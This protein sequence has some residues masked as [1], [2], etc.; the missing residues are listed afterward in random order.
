M[1]RTKVKDIW[2]KMDRGTKVLIFIIIALLAVIIIGLIVLKESK[3]TQK[4]EEREKP[5]IEVEKPE[6]IE[7]LLTVNP[8]SRPKTAWKKVNNIVVHYTANPG[9]SAENNRNY[10]EGLAD[11]GAT[12]ASSHFVIGLEG[13][14]IQCVPLDEIS[15]CSNHRNEDTV[16]IEV[17]HPDESGKF[18]DKSYEAL[19][20]LTSWL[21]YKFQL[22]ENKIIR[23]Y[24]VTEKIC[25]KYFVDNPKSFEKFKKEVGKKIHA[26]YEE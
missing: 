26:P 16:A 21:C 22:Q 14:I 17:C 18:T 6:I 9:T 2:N 5:I 11:S 12:Y 8:Y 19:V 3:I 1:D 13:E 15:Y 7:Q 25:P 20:E 4:E 24:D 10:F 23:H